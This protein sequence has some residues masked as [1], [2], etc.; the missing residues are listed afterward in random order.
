MLTWCL[1]DSIN[2]LSWSLV[3]CVCVVFNWQLPVS[4]QDRWLWSDASSA[5][6]GRPLR[7]VRT[8]QSAICMVSTSLSFSKCL[9]AYQNAFHMVGTSCMFVI[10][11]TCFLVFIWLLTCVFCLM[12]SSLCVSYCVFVDS[13]CG[14]VVRYLPEEPR[15]L[16]ITSCFPWSSHT[17][18]LNI[19]TAVAALLAGWHVRVSA[20]TV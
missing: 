20:R 19:D 3:V 9:L 8:S 13:L 2:I 16:G 17:S 14:L 18:D 5:Q 12:S 7:N 10:T 4:D 1:T 6:P 15:D 11:Y